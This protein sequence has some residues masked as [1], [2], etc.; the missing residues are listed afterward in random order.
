MPFVKIFQSSTFQMQFKCVRWLWF[1]YYFHLLL[2]CTES[3]AVFFSEGGWSRSIEKSASDYR[4]IFAQYLS[5]EM[6]K[7]QKISSR[8]IK[9]ESSSSER[10]KWMYIDIYILQRTQTLFGLIGTNQK[11]STAKQRD[12]WKIAHKWDRQWE[13]KWNEE[14]ENDWEKE[15]MNWRNIQ[16]RANC[17]KVDAREWIN[18]IWY[19]RVIVRRRRRRQ[20]RIRKKHRHCVSYS[21]RVYIEKRYV[22]SGSPCSV[23]INWKRLWHG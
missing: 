22:Q 13:S 7:N 8:P 11:F 14:C 23:F 18:F 2:S 4:W 9:S 1:P 21:K 17:R 5:S 16:Q 12:S 6:I 15:R 10:E 19:K 20:R 3:I